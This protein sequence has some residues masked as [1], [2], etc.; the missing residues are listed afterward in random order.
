MNNVIKSAERLTRRSYKRKIITMGIS[1]FS[2]LALFATGFASWVL[3]SGAEDSQSGNISVGVV[4]DN[5]V[6]F[7]EITL[8]T[9]SFSFNP[10]KNDITGRVQWDGT[11]HEVLSVTISVPI[12]GYNNIKNLKIGMTLPDSILKAA[13]VDHSGGAYNDPAQARNYI[14]L[15]DCSSYSY[16][17]VHEYGFEPTLH[18]ETTPQYVTIYDESFT[19]TDGSLCYAPGEGFNDTWSVVEQADGTHLFTYTV[20]F[21]WGKYFNGMNPSEYFDIVDGEGNYSLPVNVVAAEL[22]AFRAAMFGMSIN[23]YKALSDEDKAALSFGED[24]FKIT[25]VAEAKE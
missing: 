14:I 11:N 17:Y 24:A 5:S 10:A 4:N 6:T 18:K 19:S 7:G 8:S 22:D 12:T 13:A 3:S 21:L 1:I 16:S 9:N 25:I 23:D 15:P 20:N 2:A